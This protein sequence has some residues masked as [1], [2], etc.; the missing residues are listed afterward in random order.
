VSGRDGGDSGAD[1]A[2][3]FQ[4]WRQTLCGAYR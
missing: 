1:C 2:E 3:G 4:T